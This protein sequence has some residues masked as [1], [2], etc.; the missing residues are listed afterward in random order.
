[1]MASG[2]PTLTPFMNS[3]RFITCGRLLA[4]AFLLALAPV[5]PAREEVLLDF[6]HVSRDGPSGPVIRCYTY[7][8]NDWNKKIMDLPGKGALI[9]APSGKG[10]L[11]EDKTMLKLNKT[12]EIEIQY[13]VGNANQAGT[14]NFKLVDKDGTEWTWP[15]P[16]NG[17]ARGTLQRLR[18]DL[19]KPG[20]EVKPGKTAGLNLAKLDVWEVIGDWGGARVEVLLIKVVAPQA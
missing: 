5:L 9:Q 16:L 13:L 4:A 3:P 20:N 14:L 19:T 15:I 8:W 1:M 10:N 18:L 17:L 7:A 2:S 11:G 6:T 12:P